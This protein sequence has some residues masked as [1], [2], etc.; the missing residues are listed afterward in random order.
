[1]IIKKNKLNSYFI[2]NFTHNLKDQY[3]HLRRIQIKEK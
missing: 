3:L 1:M 2:G